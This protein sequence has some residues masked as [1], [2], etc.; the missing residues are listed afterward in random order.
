MEKI[1]GIVDGVNNNGDRYGIII[2]GI[3]YNGIGASL[4]N[5]G[6][7]VE[8]E[9]EVNGT[10]N[11]IKKMTVDKPAAPPITPAGTS[12]MSNSDQAKAVN[13]DVMCAKDIFCALLNS[14]AEP[15][16]D[17]SRDTVNFMKSSISL[18]KQARESFS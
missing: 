13:T 12:V 2:G 7:E 18:V 5:K 4:V 14:D 11:N 17:V 9:F 1:K 10:F 15:A 16:K 3:W 6:D 8:I